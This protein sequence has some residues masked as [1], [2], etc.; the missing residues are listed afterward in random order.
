M[1]PKITTDH[2][3]RQ[4]IV[5]IRQSSPI[6]VTYNLESQVPCAPWEIPPEA[7]QSEQVLREVASVKRGR[8]SRVKLP[9]EEEGFPMFAE[10]ESVGPSTR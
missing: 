4:A 10:I 5:Y 2:L 9:S 1:N 6:Q 7:I 8:G 3:K